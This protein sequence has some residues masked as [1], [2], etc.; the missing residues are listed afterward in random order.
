MEKI[1]TTHAA[2]SLFSFPLARLASN[3]ITVNS[4]GSEK[5]EKARVAAIKKVRL[6]FLGIL[7]PFN[8]DYQGSPI[9]ISPFLPQMFVFGR[10]RSSG[11]FPAGATIPRK[12]AW[13]K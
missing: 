7:P 5:R 3:R 12:S 4:L 1:V 2:F 6:N 8:L 10:V 13:D 9:I 11:I